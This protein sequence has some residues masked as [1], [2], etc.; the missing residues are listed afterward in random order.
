MTDQQQPKLEITTSRLFQSWLGEIQSSIALTT[1]QAG[2]LFWLGT[3]E[4]GRL[5]VFE[6]TLERV[7]GLAVNEDDLYVS[8]LYQL[9]RF[10]NVLGRGEQYNGFDRVFMPRE[11]RV[12]GDIDI[13]DISV[14]KDDRLLFVSTLFNCVATTDRDH[15]FKPVWKPEW[16]S[17]IVPEDRCHLN[18][19]ALRD[20]QLRYVTSVSRS[21]VSDAWRD[22]RENSGVVVDT[23]SNEVICEGLSMP[24]SPRW[25][26]GQLYVLNSGTGYFGRIDLQRGHFE[27]ITF[28]PGYARGLAMHG[29]W[30][31]I[32]LSD[33][34]ENKTF[35]GLALEAE[36]EK[37]EANSRCGLQIVDLESGAAP[38]WLRMQGVVRELYD[39]AIIPGAKRPMGV[40]F[41]TDEVR[42]MVS[43]P[44][45]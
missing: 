33:R 19:M 17:Q 13:H 25:H 32:G 41:K 10:R 6:R 30:A 31:V 40:G 5:S 20:G 2:K 26:N 9:W 37:R 35:Q 14:D 21:D 44:G 27:P 22:K 24:H 11:S 45:L 43:H 29:K 34:R 23:D 38:H 7:M 42:R 15:N 4:N 8:T 16:I 36:L 12:T 18:G 28:V 3:Q 1:Y 39:V